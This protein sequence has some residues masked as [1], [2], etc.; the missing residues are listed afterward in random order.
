MS[1]LDALPADQRAVLQLLLK[2]GKSYGDLAGLLR[3]SDDTVRARAHTALDALAPAGGS[4]VP[5]HRREELGD[6][7]L[8]QQTASQ[9][10]A[11][12][13]YLDDDGDA[14]AWA[15]GVTAELRPLGGDALPEIP[16]DGAEVDEA[17][18]A[19]DA[20][21]T[22]HEGHQRS[23]RLGGILLLVGLGIA[24]AVVVVLIVSG[25]SDSGD[26]AA[27]STSTPA[28]SSTAT[29]S[30]STSEPQVVAQIN[31]TPPGGGTKPL[32]V[33]NVVQ[34]NGQTALAI[35]AQDLAPSTSTSFYAVWLYSGPNK[36]KRLGFAPAVGKNGNLKAVTQVPADFATY[37]QLVITK[38]TAKAPTQ[39]GP[40][41]LAGRLPSS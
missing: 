36:A 38:E 9:R 35:A 24:V 1:R 30:T 16:A 13:A 2:Q 41:Q 32:G 14:R 17:F 28:A 4:A 11:S 37:A 5:E 18:V 26:S 22:A 8:G 20:R 40:I 6:Y 34:Q 7:L 39:P 27:V 33:A 3:I 19:L 21:R 12:R 29:T 15:R 23:S 31:M 10:A 25:G